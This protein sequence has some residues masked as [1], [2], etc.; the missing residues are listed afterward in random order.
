MGDTRAGYDAIA[1]DYLELVRDELARRPLERAMLAAFADTVRDEKVADGLV[2]EIGCG[3]GRIT[4]HLHGLGVNIFG[5]DLSP[6]MLALAR[7]AHPGLRFEE[8]SMTALD[9]PTGGLAGLVAW[10]SLIHIPPDHRPGVLAEFYR[11]LAP[12]GRLLLGF[13]V[14]DRPRVYTEAFGHTVSLVF[15]RLSM[16][17][18]ADLLREAGFEVTTRVLR[19]PEDSEEAQQGCL[20]ARKPALS[21]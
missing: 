7:K 9:L 15:H 2:A 19:E 6:Q 17:G 11:V 13:Q 21:T 3:P 10:Y 14:G 16:D 8:G 5:I 12:G 4:A 1:A 20:L 18:T